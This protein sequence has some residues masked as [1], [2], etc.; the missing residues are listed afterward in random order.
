ML[1]RDNPITLLP[2]SE[3]LNMLCWYYLQTVRTQIRT[4]RILGLVLV[5]NVRHSVDK[6]ESILIKAHI[7]KT[8]AGDNNFQAG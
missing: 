3:Y 5:Q 4:Q 2:A 6:T 7:K 8:L 1:C